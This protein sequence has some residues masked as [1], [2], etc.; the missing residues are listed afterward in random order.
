MSVKMP[1]MQRLLAGIIRFRDTVRNDLVKQFEKIRDNPSPTAAFFTCMDS[2]MLPAR[3]TQSNVGDMFVVRN[4]GNMVPHATH[5]GAAGYEVSVTTEPAALELAV[6]RGHIHHV[7]VCGHADCKAINLLYNL[8]KSPK[9]FDPQSPMDH[10]IRRH[11]FASLQKLEQRLEDREKPLEF[12]SDVEG[13]TFEAYIDPEDK[14]GTEDKLSQ[15]NTL[16]QL[17]NIASHGFITAVDIV[18]EG[19]ADKKVFK[20]AL[21]GRMLK[22]Q[23]G[24][25]LQI[26]SEA[27][28]LAIAEEW[29]SQ[30]EFLHM[31]HMRLTGLAFTAQDNPLNATRESI[32]SKIMEYL[33]GDTI[34]FWNVESEKLEKYQKQYWQ[35]VIDNANEGLGTSL[36]PS[37]NLFGG[38][39]ISSVDASKVEKWLKSHN[40]WA[41][42]GMQY[43]VESVKS[44][45]LPYSVVTFKLSASE[46]VHSALIEQKAQAETWGAVEWAHGVEEQELT[47]RLCA[48][49][50]F[51]Y[52]N[53]NTIT[54]MR[55]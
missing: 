51:V 30:E 18:E 42:T 15:I 36:K 54:K 13:Y 50:L 12:V 32:A 53:S 48:G 49:A 43:A 1:G 4:S 47:S 3:F 46:A 44:V 41:L 52:M 17:E 14:W 25:I 37:T 11:G 24:K 34:L 5:Y 29:S 2:R 35:P 40:F 16:Q 8:H 28:A 19:T 21:D 23:S 55:F 45:L 6:K 22:T 27:L 20:V 39:T 38:D 31:G 9:N 7:I 10:W 33:H 26:E